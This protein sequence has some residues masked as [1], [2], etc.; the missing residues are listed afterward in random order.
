LTPRPFLEMSV[1]IRFLLI[2]AINPY[3]DIQYRWPNLGLGYLIS[4]LRSH[5]GESTFQFRVIDH[6]TEEELDGFKPHVVGIT[7]VSQNY[8][9]AKKYAHVVKNRNIPVIIGGVHISALPQTMTRDM[10]LAVI[11]EG[12]ETIIPVMDVFL[13]HSSFPQNELQEIEGIAFKDDN[14][15]LWQTPRRE[16]ISPLDKIKYPARDMIKIRSHSNM[17]SSR[18]C[19]YK[20]TFCFSTRYWDQLRFFSAEY[21]VNE[22][23]ELVEKYKVKR[24]SFFDDLIIANRDRLTEMVELIRREQ[25][26]SKIEFGVNARANLVTEET[27]RLL[28]EMGVTSVGMGLESGNEKTLRYLKGGS[29]SVADNYAAIKNLQKYGI[30]ANA[31]FVI[32][33]PDETKE[34]IMDTYNFIK[35]SGLN[36]VNTFV[37]VPLPGTPVWDYAKSIGIVSENMDWNRLNI[38]YHD[39]KNP[40]IVSSKVTKQEMDKI[41]RKFYRQRIFLAAK[42]AWFH[43][44]FREMCRAGVV[45][46]VAG[47]KRIVNNFSFQESLFTFLLFLSFAAVSP[48]LLLMFTTAYVKKKRGTWFFN[49]GKELK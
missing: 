8:N 44:L 19:P 24:I 4:S 46:T 14:E 35:T 23:K 1:S 49:F 41:Y 15:K 9:F 25:S 30:A 45:K 36:F 48:L 17:F 34:E 33:S 12:E 29:V 31:S 20:C 10:D 27:A 5:F 11:G 7:S 22:I 26:L 3:A 2:N 38:Y 6:N 32:G 21:V 42:T 37:L 16:L 28:S 43:P 39:K 13:K 40:V 47:V 18:G